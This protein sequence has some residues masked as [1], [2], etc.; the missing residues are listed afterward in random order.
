MKKGE[1]ASPDVSMGL[2]GSGDGGFEGLGS[3]SEGDDGRGMGSRDRLSS[4]GTRPGRVKRR[5]G[6]LVAELEGRVRKRESGR[7][8]KPRGSMVSSFSLMTRRACSHSSLV[9]RGS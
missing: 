8:S 1:P 2:G 5:V 7:G 4:C 9:D 3:E 6:E